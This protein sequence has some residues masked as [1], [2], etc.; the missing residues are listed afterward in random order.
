MK[1]TFFKIVVIITIAFGVQNVMAQELRF[2]PSNLQYK[3]HNINLNRMTVTNYGSCMPLY[4]D[5]PWGLLLNYPPGSTQDLTQEEGFWLGAIVNG[6][7]LVSTGCNYDGASGL[8]YLYEF[9]PRFNKNDT[10]YTKSVYEEIPEDA[11]E[12]LFFEEDG[13]LSPYYKPKS[14]QDYIS[15]YW[16]DKIVYG[17]NQAPSI[18]EYHIPLHAHVI[19]RTFA[20]S[21]FLYDKVIF[22]EYFIINEGE[23]IWHDVWFAYYNDAHMGRSRNYNRMVDDYVQFDDERKTLI[24]ADMVGGPDGTTINDALTG[25]RFVKTPK[26]LND[27]TL[28]YTFAHWVNNDDPIG[29]NNVYRLMSSGERMP[30]MSPDLQA[31]QSVRGLLAVGP[32][33][34]VNPG[35]TIHF[36]YAFSVGDG[37]Q[38]L[39]KNVDAA[40]NLADAGF[41]VPV[42]PSPPKFTL[43][44]KNGAVIINWKW[45]DE[46]SGINPEEFEDHSRRDGILKDFDGYKIYR[47]SEGPDGPWQ[48]IA[49]YDSLNGFGY[50]TGLKYE[51]KDEGLV[52][53]IKYWYAVTSFDIPEV[54][55]DELTI[56]SLESPKTLSTQSVIPAISPGETDE[57]GVFVVP[58]PYRGDID[59]TH[60]PA[61]EY[62]TQPGRD[63]WMEVDRRIAFM[64]LPP[65]CTIYIYTLAGYLVKQIDF[66]QGNGSPIAYWNL[67]NKNN[68]T[69][70]SG[71]YYFVVKEPSGKTQ[72]GKFVIVK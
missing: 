64:N 62:P 1:K 20:W 2:P 45:K 32:F 53:G 58:N 34:S 61:W 67:L 72:V 63:V 12:N 59:Y 15:E 7:T 65:E 66:T 71:L 10:I 54:V 16:D 48:L 68:H 51:Y 17:V 56:P 41:H 9:F 43:T 39:L 60:D 44:P 6:D 31:G 24:F 29:D 37:K 30:D 33:E 52:N 27:A 50:D 26:D 36:V 28:K 22:Y 11:R 40:K 18:L 69:V 35:D 38:D 25:C 5:Q 49:Q 8:G 21:F 19:Q 47:S 4:N 55:S 23:D 57:K 3:K 13:S 42:S 70:A 46:Y 14:E